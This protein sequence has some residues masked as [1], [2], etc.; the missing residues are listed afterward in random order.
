MLGMM[1][2]IRAGLGIGALPVALGGEDAELVRTLGPIKDLAR[3]WR[4][5]IHPDV[6]KTQRLSVFFDFFVSES[7]ALKPILTG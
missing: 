7:K 5:P 6:R 2:A 3:A 4:I 1:R